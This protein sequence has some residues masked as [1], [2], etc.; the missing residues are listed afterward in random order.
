MAELLEHALAQLCHDQHRY[1]IKMGPKLTKFLSYRRRRRGGGA[2]AGEA[3]I[4]VGSANR[5]G[6]W[7]GSSE[8]SER[9][10]VSS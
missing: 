2:E 8:V 10:D 1:T 5:G 7:P 3:N 9:V 4:H 6:E